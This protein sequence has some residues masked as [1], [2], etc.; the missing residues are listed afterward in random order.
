MER[1]GAQIDAVFLCR[2]PGRRNS[3]DDTYAAEAIA[4]VEAGLEV[5]LIDHDA[6]VA[7]DFSKAVCGVDANGRG[8]R[9]LY[10]GWML[11]T[12]MY[13][14]VVEALKQLD[15]HAVTS[16]QDYESCHHLVGWADKLGSLTPRSE[17][18]PHKPPFTHE[19]LA[20]LLRSFQ[21]PVIV[22]DYVKSEKHAWT[23]ACFVPDARDVTQAL[24]VIHRFIELRD[25][26]FEG[27]L[28]LREFVRLK[29]IGTD[30]RSGM[31]LSRELRSFWQ[32]TTCIAVSDYWRHDASEP[33]PQVAIEAA[34]LIDRPFFTIDLA[35]TE[36]GDWVVIEVGDGQVSALPDS[37]D[38]R[39]LFAG[40][41]GR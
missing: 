16:P 21:G 8:R 40:L 6:A 31:P 30:E 7:G 11:N 28:V 35:M 24:G 12:R 13:A 41:V 23:Q 4:A 20:D 15:W 29:P 26:D 14:G 39:T 25:R 3:V 38:A 33:L 2:Q 18:I 34:R 17:W 27:G 36:A 1:A 37:L 5:V 32:G 22:K 19:E 10:R 9:Y